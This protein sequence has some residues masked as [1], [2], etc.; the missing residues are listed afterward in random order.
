MEGVPVCVIRQDIPHAAAILA[1][2]EY[3]VFRRLA[4]QDLLH[5]EVVVRKGLD[6]PVGGLHLE[7]VGVLL[8]GA[9]RDEVGVPLQLEGGDS[10]IGGKNRAAGYLVQGG[11]QLRLPAEYRLLPQQRGVPL[12]GLPLGHGGLLVGLLD[13]R[14]HG[15][16]HHGALVLAVV[17]GQGI[18]TAQGDGQVADG[19]HPFRAAHQRVVVPLG[20]EGVPRLGPPQKQQVGLLLH[21][22]AAVLHHGLYLVHGA[23]L[24]PQG[25]DIPRRLAKSPSPPGRIYP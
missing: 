13:G 23:A 25:D 17:H 19:V 22:G 18:I 14:Q 4:P 7:A 16:L 10:C 5:L 20:G 2:G 24:L 11:Q 6:A 15:V 12:G 3:A 21:K 9:H 1:Q 8:V